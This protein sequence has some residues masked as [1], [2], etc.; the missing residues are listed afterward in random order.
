MNIVSYTVRDPR[1][2]FHQRSCVWDYDFRFHRR[3][4]GVARSFR[5]CTYG[6]HERDRIK[7]GRVFRV[8]LLVQ[9]TRGLFSVYKYTCTERGAEEKRKKKKQL[10]ASK[11]LVMYPCVTK[12]H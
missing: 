12:V 3:L 5:R 1:S 2:Y 8:Y 4:E 10:V 9:K 11:Y 7:D 6:P